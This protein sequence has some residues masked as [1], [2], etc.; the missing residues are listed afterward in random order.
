MGYYGKIK[1][2]FEAQKLR[3]KG[4]S[5]RKIEEKLHVSRSSV[6]LWVRDIKLPSTFI[7][8][9]YQNQRTGGL[10]GSF[11][12]AQNKVKKREKLIFT[13]VNKAR[14][15]VGALTKR[16][17]FIAGMSLYLA[18]GDKADRRV[19]F[20]NADPR[21]I[22]F[23][24]KWLRIICFVPEK[25]FRCCIYIHDNLDEKAAKLYWSKITD[26][27]LSQFMKSYIVKNKAQ[28]F[29]RTKHEYGICR[30]VVCDVNLHRK[31]MGWIS[32]AFRL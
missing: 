15:E 32:G 9:L 4:W 2:R 6:S 3:G 21:T 13:I 14:E 18:E 5:I 28:R 8:K 17:M 19:A 20:S 12:A 11:I 31:I 24:M 30:I 7:K 1:L 10:R 26:I 16:D 22:N 27:S 23:M 25:K 29:R